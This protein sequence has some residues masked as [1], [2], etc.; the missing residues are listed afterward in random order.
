MKKYLIFIGGFVAGI[1]A[2]IFAGYLLSIAYK[3]KDDGLIGLTIFEEKGDCLTTTSKSK[4]SEIDIFQVIAP[5]AALANIKYYTDEN[6]YDG[7]TYRNY[8]IRNDVVI[9]L[10]NYENKT[11]YD[12]QKII[13]LTI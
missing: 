12:N 10:I 11:F 9:L 3:A 1:L 6:L 2:T 13:V 8:D 7:D 4:S 5:N